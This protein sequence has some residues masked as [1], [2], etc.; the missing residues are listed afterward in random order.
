VRGALAQQAREIYQSLSPDKQQITQKMFRRLAYSE[1]EIELTRRRARREEVYPAGVDH[2]LVD[3]VLNAFAERAHLLSAGDY[4]EVAHEALFD[5]WP[6]LHAWLTS[7]IEDTRALLRLARDAQ[8]WQLASQREKEPAATTAGKPL[9]ARQLLSHGAQLAHGLDLQRRRPDWLNDLEI[10]YLHASKKV[11]DQQRLLW[12]GVVLAV[13]LVV[14]GYLLYLQILRLQARGPADA[15][16]EFPAGLAVMGVQDDPESDVF[17]A[18]RV[19][20]E[21]FALEKTEVSYRQYRLCMRAGVCSRPDEGSVADP[22]QFPGIDDAPD[23]LPVVWVHAM[24][25]WE[26]CRWVGRRLPSNA[27]WE[28]AARGLEGRLFP[29]GDDPPDLNRAWIILDTRL[30]LYTS[31]VNAPEAIA[32]ATPEGV[33]HMYGNVW[34]WTSTPAKC[35][36]GPFFCKSLWDG[37][38]KSAEGLLL[39]GLAFTEDDSIPLEAYHS[40]TELSFENYNIGFRCAEDR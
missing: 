15:L 23:E 40:A 10:D 6:E 25:A 22:L 29:W 16:V 3:E 5:A 24:Q 39:R 12:G 26:Y 7:D 37:D 4:V 35:A 9:R 1:E 13:V 18:E 19:P 11:R 28:R 38:P 34:E 36:E 20:V 27:E 31:P 33:V 21:P 14:G 32:G 2:Q 17:L 8:D 30:P